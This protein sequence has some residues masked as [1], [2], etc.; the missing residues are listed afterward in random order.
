MKVKANNIRYLRN[1][2]PQLRKDSL[3]KNLHK[4]E[5]IQQFHLQPTNKFHNPPVKNDIC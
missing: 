4:F 1:L 2:I 5:V 3:I